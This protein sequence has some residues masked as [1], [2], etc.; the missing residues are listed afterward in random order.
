[1]IPVLADLRALRA[2]ID[3]AVAAVE[4]ALGVRWSLSLAALP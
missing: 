2:A 1:M 4:L 3:D